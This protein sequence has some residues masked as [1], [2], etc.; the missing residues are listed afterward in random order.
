[1]IV[2]ADASPLNYL[3]LIECVEILERLYGRVL[4]PAA[5]MEELR[6]FGAPTAVSGWANDIPKWIEIR[7]I[8]FRQDPALDLLDPGERE[9]IQLAEEQ[10]ADLLLVDERQG[11]RVASLRGISTT[12]TLGVLLAAGK[13]NLLDAQAAYERLV[14]QTSFRASPGVREAFLRLC[15]EGRKSKD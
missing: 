14:S 11:R 4:V 7:Q 3:I 13:R 15:D 5:V 8:T 6:H 9:A 12:G 1:M 2:V 10:R